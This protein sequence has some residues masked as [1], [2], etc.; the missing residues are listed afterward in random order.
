[1]ARPSMFSKNYEQQVK[2]R[3]INTILIVLIA[4]CACFFI[5]KYYAD[6]YKVKIFDFKKTE[7]GNNEKTKPQ[8]TETKPKTKPS[9]S[10]EPTNVQKPT[11]LT[12]DYTSGSGT[13]YKVHYTNDS[14]NITL[15]SVESN[16]GTVNSD[17]S[18]DKKYIVFDDTKAG[19]VIVCGTDGTFKPIELSSYASK[20]GGVTIEKAKTLSANPWYVWAAKP[21]FTSDSKMIVYVSHLPYIFQGTQLT[22]WI[23]SPDGSDSRMIGKLSTSDASKIS[24]NNFDS[25]GR[26]IIKSDSDTYYLTAGNYNLTR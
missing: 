25:D 17:I 12:Y 23:T 4:I 5:G 21:H 26:L 8:K 15:T 18:T 7:V 9:T 1:M 3:K 14:G 13:A 20:S 19:S 2:Q 10:S 24:Y 11:D 22:L 6:K 16:G